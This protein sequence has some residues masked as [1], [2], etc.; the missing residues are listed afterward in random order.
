MR[1]IRM[2]LHNSSPTADHSKFKLVADGVTQDCQFATFSVPHCITG[3]IFELHNGYAWE[4]QVKKKEHYGNR[5]HSL[6]STRYRKSNSLTW[7]AFPNFGPFH[8]LILWQMQCLVLE[9]IKLSKVWKT[10]LLHFVTLKWPL[11]TTSY[12][13]KIHSLI[14]STLESLWPFNSFLICSWHSEAV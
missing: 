7:L 13:H 5:L 8:R 4:Y 2:R 1:M 10:L 3:F 9:G 14:N 12:K 11:F 6:T